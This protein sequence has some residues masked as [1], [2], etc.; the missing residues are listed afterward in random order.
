MQQLNDA[1]TT[2]TRA[3]QVARELL[4]QA[5]LYAAETP[6]AARASA[7]SALAQRQRSS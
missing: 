2:L 3:P 5:R 6:E 7:G 4:A 1:S